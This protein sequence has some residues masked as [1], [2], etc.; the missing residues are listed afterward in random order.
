MVWCDEIGVMAVRVVWHDG[1][2]IG[3]WRMDTIHG[4]S[5]HSGVGVMDGCLQFQLVS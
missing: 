3:V 5:R 4:A 2:G 1:W